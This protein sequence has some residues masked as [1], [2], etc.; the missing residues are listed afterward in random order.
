MNTQDKGHE[1]KRVPNGTKMY[2][3]LSGGWSKVNY[4]LGCPQASLYSLMHLAAGLPL[5]DM[6][7]ELAYS[8]AGNQGHH[9]AVAGERFDFS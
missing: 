4:F 8:V 7:N 5:V 1:S 9:K 2:R 3:G 6:P